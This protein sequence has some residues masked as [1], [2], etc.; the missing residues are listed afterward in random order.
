VPVRPTVQQENPDGDR[1]MVRV[2]AL[3]TGIGSQPGEIATEF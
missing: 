3:A 2:G 1:R